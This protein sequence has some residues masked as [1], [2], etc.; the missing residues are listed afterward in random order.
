MK[1]K[2]QLVWFKRYLRWSDHLP[3]HQS[4]LLGIPTL[5]FTLYEP[6][7]YDLPQYDERHVRFIA[8]S[9][10]DMNSQVGKKVVYFFHAEAIKLFKIL[11]SKYH[12]VRVLSHKETGIKCTFDRDIAVKKYL[13]SQQIEWIQS[14]ANGVQRGI[15]NR[16]DWIKNWYHD[17]SKPLVNVDLNLITT[18]SL[19]GEGIAEQFSKSFDP[20]PFFQRG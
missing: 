13:Q 11:I 14:D 20:H 17:A 18:N 9:V 2:I 5:Y 4:T 16:N 10:E 12:V 6:S 1:P 7:L 15:R 3:A 8:D 19:N